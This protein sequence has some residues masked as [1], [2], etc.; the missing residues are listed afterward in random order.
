MWQGISTWRTQATIGSGGGTGGPAGLVTLGD[1]ANQRV[2]QIGGGGVVETVAGL[3]GSA[4]ETLT[5]AGPAVIGYGGGSVTATLGSASGSTAAGSV[6]F[7]DMTGTTPVPL[8]TVALGNNAA[9]L[10]TGGRAAGL[11]A[12]MAT[13]GG[14]AEHASAESAV[15]SV[16]IA[17]AVVVASPAAVSVP[18]GAAIP[19]LT[20]TATG[21]LEQD[22]G[23]VAVV[24]LDGGALLE[25]TVLSATG[26]GVFH[27]SFAMAGEQE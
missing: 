10:E 18:Y 17:P 20:G 22:A 6:V 11:H 5:L 27:V 3:G 1:T 14:D 7:L 15:L 25:S 21:L 16:Q 26:V 8:A 19:A 2:R 23:R 9:G 24:L 13:Y 4:A 12:L